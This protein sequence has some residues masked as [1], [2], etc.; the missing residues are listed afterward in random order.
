[1][2]PGL[3]LLLPPLLGLLSLLLPPRRV[4]CC[5]VPWDASLTA[6]VNSCER[7]EAYRPKVGAR[8]WL[9]GADVGLV[10]E[11]RL[12]LLLLLPL[13]PL[14]LAGLLCGWCLWVAATLCATSLLLHLPDASTC[15]VACTSLQR[16]RSWSMVSY[17]TENSAKISGN[18]MLCC[19]AI[20]LAVL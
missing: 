4:L 3:L 11:R 12:L 16:S 9:L 17:A 5:A 19:Q 15:R 20:L 14:P 10:G 6:S 7:V 8:A 2:C 13:P 18:S 1:M